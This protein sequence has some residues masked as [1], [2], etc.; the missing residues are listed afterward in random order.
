VSVRGVGD[1]WATQRISWIVIG[2]VIVP[3]VIMA[4]AFGVWLVQNEFAASRERFKQDQQDRLLW[5]ARALLVEV[6]QI[7][8][9]A[10]P[11]AEACPPLTS[12][13]C[14]GAPPGLAALWR[15]PAGGASPEAIGPVGIPAE[16]G[17]ETAWLSTADGAGPLGLFRDGPDLVAFRLDVGALDQAAARIGSERFPDG[18]RF[19]IEAPRA[20]PRSDLQELVAL[21]REGG[22]RADIPLDRP[23]AQY[24]LV[25]RFGEV[26][27][28][29]AAW[30]WFWSP[31]A[32]GLLGLVTTVIVGAII[33]IRSAY[34]EI[35][36]SRLQTDFVSNVSHELK[37]PLTS[38]RMFVEMLQ[39][40][41]IQDADRLSE[42]LG[43]LSSETDRLSRRIER[44][45]L[46]T[47][48]EAGRRLYEI[49]PVPVQA[50]VD[51]AV[52]ALRAQQLL[53]DQSTRLVIDIGPE[54]PAVQADRDAIV[55]AL[56][57]LL[58]NAVRHT[59]SPRTLRVSAS[60]RRNRVGIAV[61]DDGPGIPSR[62][63]R[64]VFEKFYQVNTLLSSPTQQ[65]SG[66]GLAIVRAVARGHGGSVTLDT[67]VGQ[68]CT[69]T[70]W[71]PAARS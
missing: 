36:L 65:G 9:A 48:M 44:V 38:I 67:E 10:R 18:S 47:R 52:Q 42:V 7:S 33:T 46:L 3:T 62:H 37:T 6:G 43:L 56:L 57:N 61:R 51:E 64:R 32:V 54:T 25:V 11:A 19:S 39:S 50:L 34:N 68:G 49:D 15:W 2:M 5:V 53:D 40:G 1:S 28:G 22:A 60:E 4:L 23:L 35:Q 58:A 20:G 14:P 29:R 8:A 69:F 55:E 13:A 41:R 31:A 12:V 66:L 63:K 30:S 21:R 59:P 24:L 26:P 70:L 16:L 17:A 27:T 45:L 71:L